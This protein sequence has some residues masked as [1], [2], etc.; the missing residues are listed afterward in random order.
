MRDAV[1]GKESAVKNGGKRGE[2][3]NIKN[4]IKL[5]YYILIF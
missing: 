5:I 3:A 4:D 2:G 1:W